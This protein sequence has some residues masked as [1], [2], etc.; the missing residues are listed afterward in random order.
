MKKI[1]FIIPILILT[2]S[3]CTKWN[4][5]DGGRAD[6]SVQGTMLEYFGKDKYNWCYVDSMIRRA[7]LESIFS[8]NDP[9]YKD[10]TFFGPTDHSIR[11]WFFRHQTY[12]KVSDVPV[13][14]CRLLIMTHLL[15]GKQVMSDDIP[16]GNYSSQ[17]MGAV[18]TGGAEYKMENDNVFWIHTFRNSYEDTPDSGPVEIRILS[19]DGKYATKVASSNIRCT[20]GVVHS[21]SYTYMFPYLKK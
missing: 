19:I 20:N 2:F 13:E 1:F 10:M 18:G 6:D 15:N 17:G 5:I 3:S 16:R 12:K 7:G 4:Y 11:A 8:G 21:L 9:K 14:E